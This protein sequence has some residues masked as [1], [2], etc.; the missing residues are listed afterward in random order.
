MMGRSYA[1][2]KTLL[3]PFEDLLRC[4]EWPNSYGNGANVQRP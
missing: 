2:M 3:A 4:G 1:T